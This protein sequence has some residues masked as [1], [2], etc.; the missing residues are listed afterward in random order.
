MVDGH[1]HVRRKVAGDERSCFT[2]PALSGSALSSWCCS[3][4]CIICS[5]LSSSARPGSLRYFS[6]GQSAVASPDDYTVTSERKKRL[7]PYDFFLK[8][9]QHR[10]ALD[11]AL[12]V[13]FSI[14]PVGSHLY[15]PSLTLSRSSLSS[16]CSCSVC[17]SRLVILLSSSRC[18]MS[19]C[20]VE[21]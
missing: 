11:A 17:L 2:L 10:N 12:E 4:W 5:S 16:F 19:C 18:W 9:F 6:R 15:P 21:C 8:K 3:S 1:L 13:W 7:Q 14:L 20:N